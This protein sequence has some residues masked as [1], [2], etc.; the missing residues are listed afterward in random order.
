MAGDAKAAKPYAFDNKWGSFAF[1]GK[2]AT[3]GLFGGMHFTTF[4]MA[5][6]QP[7]KEGNPVTMKYF[8]FAGSMAG[9]GFYDVDKEEVLITDGAWT[10]K[11]VKKKGAA[12]IDVA[13]GNPFGIDKNLTAIFGH[14]GAIGGYYGGAQYKCPVATVRGTSTGKH[15]IFA[16]KGSFAGVDAAFEITA[17]DP[18]MK[19]A[20]GKAKAPNYLCGASYKINAPLN[21][22]VGFMATDLLNN[23]MSLYAFGDVDGLPNTKKANFGLGYNLA[24]NNLL[25]GLYATSNT[26]Y[27]FNARMNLSTDLN[28]ANSTIEGCIKRDMGVKVVGG[29]KTNAA[30][31]LNKASVGFQIEMKK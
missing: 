26:G 17:P 10:L 7:S 31:P 16:A 20:D 21:P 14:E 1:A 24:N 4:Q 8:G 13:K 18:D 11:A 5:T 25:L 15:H 23:Q 2:S 3:T 12:G 19:G 22:H 30:D 28:L 27:D 9:K 29:L 6:P